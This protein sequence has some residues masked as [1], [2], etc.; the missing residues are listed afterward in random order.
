[1]FRRQVINTI[2]R[3]NHQNCEKNIS[4]LNCNIFF[5][6]NEQQLNLIQKQILENNANITKVE[7][8]LDIVFFYS[9]ISTIILGYK[10][11]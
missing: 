2:R 9:I 10:V 6:K 5:E 7:G 11:I 4:Q 3:Y 8:K 1:M